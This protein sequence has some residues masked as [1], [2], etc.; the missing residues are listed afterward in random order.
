MPYLT[1]SEQKILSL[2]LSMHTT[3]FSKLIKVFSFVFL[4]EI[5]RSDWLLSSMSKSSE[6]FSSLSS[7][8]VKM[9]SG[10]S[11]KIGLSFLL[12]APEKQK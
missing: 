1:I 4:P 5:L 12:A 2:L 7:E 9:S 6:D 11:S 10:F 8:E 3:V